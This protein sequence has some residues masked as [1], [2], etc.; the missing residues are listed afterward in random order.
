MMVNQTSTTN[1]ELNRILEILVRGMMDHLKDNFLGA[2]LGGSFAH[3]GWDA[4]SDVDFVVILQRDLRPD[5][6]TELRVLHARVFINDSYW[7]RHLEGSYFPKEVISDLHKTDIPMWYL[8]NGSLN[9][10]RSTHDNTL[11]VRWVLREYGIPLAGPP[12]TT[13]I[14]PIPDVLLKKE[15]WK[16]MHDWGTEIL[17]DGYKLDTRWSQAFAVMIYCRMLQTLA[18]GRVESKPDG[19]AWAM[20]AL[21]PQWQSLIDDALINRPENH[22]KWYQPSDPKK[23]E[24]TKHFLRYSLEEGKS[25]LDG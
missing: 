19:A 5:E 8:D 4:Y 3:G 10:E 25:F 13:W 23:V 1:T 17:E 9:F 16:T 21:D 7:A 14:P 24:Q 20:G 6:L 11:V 18:T 2:Y 12:P 15:V 22:Q